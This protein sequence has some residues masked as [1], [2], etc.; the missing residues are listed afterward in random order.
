MF[1][2]VEHEKSFITSGLTIL[3]GILEAETSKISCYTFQ[4][5]KNKGSDE[6]CSVA[7]T[8]SCLYMFNKNRWSHN[9]VLFKKESTADL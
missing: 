7:L 8:F 4:K 6:T 2:C 9:V 5:A 1:S 3:K